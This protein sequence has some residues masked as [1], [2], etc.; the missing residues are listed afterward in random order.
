[1]NSL[2]STL[3]DLGVSVEDFQNI[4]VDATLVDPAIAPVTAIDE[5]SVNIPLTEVVVTEPVVEPDIPIETLTETVEPTI[6]CVVTQHEVLQDKVDQIINLQAAMERYQSIIKRGGFNGITNQTAEAIQVHIQLGQSLIGVQTKVGSMESFTAKTPHDQYQLSTVTL[7]SIREM[8]SGAG[9][10]LIALIEK[11]IEYIKRTGH[12][13]FDGILHTEKALHQLE[14]KLQATKVGGGT[15][16]VKLN[17]TMLDDG[18]EV[19]RGTPPLVMMLAQFTIVDYPQRVCKFFEDT[20]GII[21]SVDKESDDDSEYIAKLEAATKPL[22]DLIA[23]KTSKDMFPGG[24]ELDVS[25]GNLSFGVKPSEGDRE[26]LVEAPC[27]TT[28]ELRDQVRA[29]LDLMRLLKKIRP[30]AERISASGKKLLTVA[31]ASGNEDLLNKAAGYIHQANPR[32]GEVIDY[33]VRY[34]KA[35]CVAIN[36]QMK[37]NETE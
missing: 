37:A 15:G 25:E 5:P 20:A 31:K 28:K 17:A 18:G 22:E 29:L 12:N 6:D 27:S 35:Q 23:S 10:S 4:P 36:V 8:V 32:V 13:L 3:T 1:M 19:A 9:K 33:L 16:K 14:T 26:K 11:I 2:Q 30:E 24:Y 21:S 34:T 7:E